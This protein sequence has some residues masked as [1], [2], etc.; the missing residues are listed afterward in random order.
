LV[1]S[2]GPNAT[3]E[4]EMNPYLTLRVAQLHI[5]DLIEEARRERLAAVAAQHGAAKPGAG[6]RH[7]Q[8]SGSAVKLGRRVIGL[9]RTV[10]ARVEPAAD[11]R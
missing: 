2:T 4:I 9:V 1:S 10:A 5:D 6:R 8:F 3:Q 11:C 7:G